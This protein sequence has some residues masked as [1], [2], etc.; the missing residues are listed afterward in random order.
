MKPYGGYVPKDKL[1][2]D[3]EYV[4]FYKAEE[5]DREMERLRSELEHT[6]EEIERRDDDIE[7]LKKELSESRAGM[8]TADTIARDHGREIQRGKTNM[9]TL[10]EA[11]I[12]Y[13]DR[14]TWITLNQDQ[15]NPD[16]GKYLIECDGGKRAREALNE[17]DDT[18]S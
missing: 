8:R 9:D 15:A 5:V 13:A 4:E 1:E 16:Y 12:F 17:V 11:L 10:R 6:R 2:G 3:E 18:P 7:R 14:A